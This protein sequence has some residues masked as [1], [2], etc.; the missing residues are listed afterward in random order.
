MTM[1]FQRFGGPTVVFGV[2]GVTFITDPTF[3]PPGRY[4]LGNR[5][6]T[7]T[8]PAAGT[9]D[10]AGAVDVVLLSHDQHPDNLDTLG[11]AFAASVPV[12]LSTP[13]AAARLGGQVTGLD[14]WSHA[15]LPRP[16]GG[17]HV[18]VTA[19]PARHGPAGTEH[20]TG[21]VTGFV[22]HGDGLPTVY[23]SGDNASLDVVA[24]IAERFPSVDVA[25]LFG[26]RARTAL[27]G[28]ADLTLGAA[29]MLAA[30]RLLDAKTVVPVHVDGWAH[31]TE[32]VADV[33]AA[34]EAAGS[35]H[36]LR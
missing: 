33:R 19:V 27:L 22:L 29:G 16:G 17:G 30:A 6:L 31:F 12:V 10:D 7:K 11:R 35:A 25:I 20:L 23:V 1:K 9:P 28:D 3:D 14:P 13:A 32:G 4:Q 34:F 15:D 2:G 18:R 5:V 24:A 8:E 21:P 26:G 36:L